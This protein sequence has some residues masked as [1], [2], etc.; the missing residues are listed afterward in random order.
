MAAAID[1]GAYL[2]CCCP[3]GTGAV[4][5]VPLG[6]GVRHTPSWD[7]GHEHLASAARE[8]LAAT[9]LRVPVCTIPRAL[10]MSVRS[11]AR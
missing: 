8:G 10:V 9:G 7:C 3:W 4:C 2:L 1:A 11:L 6:G 5:E